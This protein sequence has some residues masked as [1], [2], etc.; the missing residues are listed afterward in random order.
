MAPAYRF[1]PVLLTFAYGQVNLVLCALV[2]ADLTWAPR[3][4]GRTL[5]RGVLVGIAA[6]LKLVPLVFVPYLFLTR[7]VKAAWVALSSFLACSLIAAAIDPSVS[8]SYWTKYV[9]DAKRVGAVFYISNQSLSGVADRLA[10]HS[11]SAIPVTIASV[12]V[13]VAGL[14]LATWA[15]RASSNFLGVLVCATTGLVVSPISWAHHLVWAVPVVLW[16]VFAPDRPKGGRL[17]AV[18]ATAFFWIAPIWNVPNGHNQELAEN[19]W[20]LVLGNSFFA[21]MAIFL[22]G[23]ALM[24]TSRRR[25]GRVRPASLHTGAV[26][27]SALDSAG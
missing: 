16:L 20:Q 24:L 18:A 2:L 19:W 15:W 5:P 22:V 9:D 21:V 1:E 10:H 26:V 25:A 13:L 23:V 3:V 27:A 12:V 6:A 7:Q 4:A 8:W 17:W 14:A 11:V